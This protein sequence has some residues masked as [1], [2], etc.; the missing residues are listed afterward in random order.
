MKVGIYSPYLDIMGGGERYVLTVV[1]FFLKRNDDVDIF[2]DKEFNFGQVWERF[3]IDIKKAKIL[4]QKNMHTNKY[5]L[6][7]WVSDGSIPLSLAKKNILHFQQPFKFNRRSLVNKL[8]LTRMNGIVC[9]SNFTKKF[10]DKTYGVSSTVLYPPVDTE[11]FKPS[12]KEK[13]ILSVGRFFSPYHP[14]NQEVLIDEFKKLSKKIPGWELVLLGGIAPE[15]KEKLETLEK[16]SQGFKIKTIPNIDFEIM[17]EYFSR[18]KIYWHAT[19][20]GYNLEEQPGK[21]EHFGITTVEAMSA[22]CVPI[23]YGGG[24]QLE[25]VTENENGLF[26]KNLKELEEKTLLVI[27]DPDLEKKMSKEA[28]KRSEDFSKQKF[29]SNL[30][31]IIK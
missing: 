9:N 3:S 7:F 26:W 31:E 1:E 5:D 18:A 23:V 21:A 27:Q 29:F 4:P 20:F 16:A 11:K 30:D 2:W 22:G 19:G 10:V 25:I 28:I 14:K 6:I 17:K 13:I 8:K 24:G 15:H 12:K